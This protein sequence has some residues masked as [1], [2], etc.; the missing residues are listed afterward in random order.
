MFTLIPRIQ[1]VLDCQYLHAA[2]P[3]NEGSNVV[4]VAL[5]ERG[6]DK[7]LEEAREDHRENDAINLRR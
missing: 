5:K 6:I 7:M 4:Q 1:T 2:R 3:M